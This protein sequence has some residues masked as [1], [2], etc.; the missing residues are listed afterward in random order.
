[1]AT[2]DGEVQPITG[3]DLWFVLKRKL[4]DLD[5]DAVI[6][7][8]TGAGI[9]I[10]NGP[11][12]EATVLIEPEDTLALPNERIEYWGELVGR[13]GSSQDHTLAEGTATLLPLVLEAPA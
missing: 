4:T 8:E 1:V 2:T 13:D 6:L 12:G 10:T 11:D 5:A 3:W 7:K 9:T